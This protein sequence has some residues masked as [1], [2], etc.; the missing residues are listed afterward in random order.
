MGRESGA[1]PP[2]L[3]AELAVSASLTAS[4]YLGAIAP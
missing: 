3:L 1:S 4:E 2:R